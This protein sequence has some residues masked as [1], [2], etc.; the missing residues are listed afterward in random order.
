MPGQLPN[1]FNSLT[2]IL[3]G[4]A[5]FTCFSFHS[6]ASISQPPW[7]T[8]CMCGG[9]AKLMSAFA[10]V[11]DLQETRMFRCGRALRTGAYRRAALSTL[12]ATERPVS[13]QAAREAS[14]SSELVLHVTRDSMLHHSDLRGP[15]HGNAVVTRTCVFAY[16]PINIS[17]TLVA[18]Q[19]EH[20]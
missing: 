1:T 11:Q 13:S 18:C 4:L 15:V 5:H 7:G 3:G 12:H 20:T 17:Q 19:T 14:G 2:C 8:P 6:H 10:D 9:E 16:A